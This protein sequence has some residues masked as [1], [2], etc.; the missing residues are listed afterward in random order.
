MSPTGRDP[1]VF[2]TAGQLRRFFPLNHVADPTLAEIRSSCV[3]CELAPGAR[4]PGAGDWVYYL[5]Q[6]SIELSGDGGPRQ[7]IAAGTLP[8]RQPL[9]PRTGE[10]AIALDPVVYFRVPINSLAT[11]TSDRP[12]ARA[13]SHDPEDRDGGDRVDHQVLLD[14]HHAFLTNRLE[15]PIM[16]DVALRIRR[17]AED[18]A[19]GV[20]E[21]AGLIQEDA[22][23]AAYCVRCANNALYAGAFEVQGP[24][25]AIMR[26]GT[27]VTRDLVLSHTLRRMFRTN[28]PTLRQP[29]LAAWRHSCEIGA[30]SY[31]LA[32]TLP[33]CDAE[34]ALLAG[35]VHDIGEVTLLNH[36]RQTLGTRRDDAT[37]AAL[38]CELRGPAGAQMLRHWG[39]EQSLVSCAIEPE[40]W[41]RDPGTTLD[42]CDLMVL[43]HLHAPPAPGLD[44]DQPA[45]STVPAYRKLADGR[46]TP[47][48]RLQAIDDAREKIEEVLLMLRS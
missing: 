28:H 13:P 32:R 40:S 47:G 16:P 43:A 38:R 6:G 42:L 37:L 3:P 20:G 11:R 48:G 35:L 25:E 24:R 10:T 9:A 8:A 12:P 2:I 21:I 14:A 27:T 17:A 29:M 30:L 5:L 1:L 23:L 34:Q 26:L 22:S 7:R 4:L 31:V 46:L 39:F 18:S 15:P 45:L 41:S 33:E 36:V 19:T 44:S